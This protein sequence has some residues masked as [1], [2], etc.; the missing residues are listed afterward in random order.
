MPVTP[1]PKHSDDA[2]IQA[3]A[4]RIEVVL[5]EWDG[6]SNEGEYMA[7]A[8]AIAKAARREDGYQLAKRL[9]DDFGIDSDFQLAELLDSEACHAVEEAFRSVLSAWIS[10]NK[11]ACPFR[12]DQSVKHKTKG[13][14]GIVVDLAP[15]LPGSV[16]VFVA[17]LGHVR[18]GLGTNAAIIAW[19]DLEAVSE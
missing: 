14:T 9:E 19:E 5:S 1:K 8:V 12:L 6:K 18:S 16:S 4:R 2:V 11:L 15:H 10:E 7:C 17:S 3:A 13:W